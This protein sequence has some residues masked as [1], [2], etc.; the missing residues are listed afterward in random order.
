[1]DVRTTLASC[2]AAAITLAA[3][4]AMAVPP[5][6]TCATAQTITVPG[7]YAA[8]S[9]LGTTIDATSDFPQTCGLGDN[10][11]VWYSFTA[12]V[13]GVWY[14]DTLNSLLFDT[15]LSI[16]S[17][18]GGPQLACNDDIDFANSNFWSAITLSLAAGQTVKI[19]VAANTADAD[20]FRINV[21]GLP[22]TANNSCATPDTIVV[23]Q[24]RSGSTLLATTDVSI[25]AISCGNQTGSG[26]GRDVFYAFTPAV[27]QP[28]AISLCGSGFDTVLAVLTNCSGSAGSIIACNDDSPTCS[29]NLNSY[30]PGVPLNAGVRYLIRVAGF[31]YV[32]ADIGTYTL[33]I[34]PEPI[35]ICCRGA[36]CNFLPV[37]TCLP[38]PGT[39]GTVFGQ[40]LACNA[41]TSTTTPCCYA[42]YNKVNGISVQDIFDYLSDWFA[43]SSLTA[44]GGNGTQT[45]TVQ[46]IFA[47]LSAWFAGGC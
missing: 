28:Y 21:V 3:S 44:I 8:V 12:P 41:S 15:T 20:V 46:S 25:P 38:A 22:N 42:N 35:G 39:A 4:A 34:T 1:M 17:S 27:T 33:L 18:C 37:S 31:D 6:D 47:F 32:P 2:G 24:A 10:L 7:L 5:N 19:R 40:G 23:N 9:I 13:A 43:G 36:V 11:D 29:F 14:F 16:Y 45:P 30:L 26:G